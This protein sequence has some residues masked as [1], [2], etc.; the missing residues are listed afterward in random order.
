MT[1]AQ[2]DPR[3]AHPA[4]ERHSALWLGWIIFSGAILMILGS[5]QTVSGLV[6]LLH[7]SYYLVTR[8]GLVVN[9]DYTVWGWTHLFLGLAAFAAGFGVMLGQMWARVAG[10]ILAGISAFVN[11][12]FIA[13]YPAWSVL[14][15]A[16][17]V[18]VIYAL[19][20]HGSD[21]KNS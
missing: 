17:D 21:A 5:F 6:A 13:A 4:A 10:I 9:V 2:L 16:M 8:N 7:D 12:A 18:I 20:V 19:A 11:M 14:I 1:Q 15:I 3:T